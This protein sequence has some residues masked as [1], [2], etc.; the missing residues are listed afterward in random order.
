MRSFED[1][2]DFVDSCVF[3]VNVF[4]SL[5]AIDSS[6]K[7]FIFWSQVVYDLRSMP[8]SWVE[9]MVKY[10]GLPGRTLVFPNALGL[11]CLIYVGHRCYTYVRRRNAFGR[12]K[13]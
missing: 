11:F 2:G 1:Y 9:R 6:V 10:F 5:M 7:L 13:I 3:T 4:A 8:G 12:V